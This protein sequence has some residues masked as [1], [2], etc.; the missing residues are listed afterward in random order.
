[1]V[2]NRVRFDYTYLYDDAGDRVQE[3]TG[4]TTSFYLTDTANPTGF[5][6][7]IEVWTSTSDNRSTATLQETYLIGD[8]VLAQADSAGNVTYLLV[9]GHGSTRL[10]VSAAGA[11]TGTI[12]YDAFGGEVSTSGSTNTIFAPPCFN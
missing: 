2:K 8:R 3:T 11:V 6:Q 1:L 10:L 9:D 4:G 5:D 12:N 7:P